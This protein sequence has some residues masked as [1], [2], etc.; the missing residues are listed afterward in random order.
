MEEPWAPRN[1]STTD[2]LVKLTAVEAQD[3]R[4]QIR[5]LNADHLGP[6]DSDIIVSDDTPSE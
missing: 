2:F 1:T 3:F 5:W 6:L 4:Q